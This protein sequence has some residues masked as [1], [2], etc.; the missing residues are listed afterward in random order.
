[1][2]LLFEGLHAEVGYHRRQARS[3]HGLACVSPVIAYFYLVAF[4]EKALKRTTY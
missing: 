4:K 2:C 3:S 1:L